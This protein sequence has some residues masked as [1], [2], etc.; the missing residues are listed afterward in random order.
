MEDLF[1]SKYTGEKSCDSLLHDL[2][3]VD[4]RGCDDLQIQ[5]CPGYAT[6]FDRW[7]YTTLVT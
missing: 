6:K 1:V 2:L 7:G 3:S 5:S 4:R